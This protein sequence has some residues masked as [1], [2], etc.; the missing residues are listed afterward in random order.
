[1]WNPQ[2]EFIN[3]EMKFMPTDMIKWERKHPWTIERDWILKNKL[4]LKEFPLE[5][6][7]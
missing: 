3:Q 7:F 4:D 2:S 1:M 5:I 6:K